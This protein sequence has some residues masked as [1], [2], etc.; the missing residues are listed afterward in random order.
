M[1]LSPVALTI[2]GSDPSGGAGLQADLKTFQT[3]GVH[4]ASAVTVLT[5]CAATGV[6]D[7]SPTRPT[8]VARQIRRVCRDF[9]PQAIK[10]GMLFSRHIVEIVARHLAVAPAVPFVFDPVITTRRGDTLVADDALNAM[11]ERLL[12]RCTL[13]TPS[14]PE[15]A[16]MTGMPVSDPRDMERAGHRLLEQGADAALVTGGHLSETGSSDFLVGRAIEPRWLEGDRIPS[17]LHGA[18]DCLS[19]SIVAGLA[20]GMK[21]ETAIDSAKRIVNRATADARAGNHDQAAIVRWI[22]HE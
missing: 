5:D 18:G 4:G 3:L 8:F 21:L 2:A 7:I 6:A 10:T 19:A 14:M 9:G 17:I 13:V 16:V 1:T 22:S 15:A 12:P 11:L 20:R